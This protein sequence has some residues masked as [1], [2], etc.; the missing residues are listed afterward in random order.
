VDGKVGA[1]VSHTMFLAGDLD[2]DDNCEVGVITT[3]GGKALK[4][5]AAQGLYEITLREEFARMN[6]LTGSLTLT[7]GVQARATDKSISD[8]L[9]GTVVW[10]YNPMECPQTIVRLYKGMMKAYVNQSSSYEGST[11]VVEHQDKDQAAGLEVA[12]LFILCGHHAFR[13][14]IK[15][16]AVFVPK[17]DRMEVAQGRFNGKEGEADLTR[18]ESGMSFM[19][20]RASMS[21]KEKLRQVRR[22]IC[23][24]RRD[25]ARTR[26]EAI[27]GAD[28]PYSLISIFG[29][30]HLAIKAGRAVYVTKCSP[31][32][33]VRRTHTNCTEEIPVVINGTEAFVDPISYVIKS[34]GA[35][36]HCNDV[37]PP[38]YKVGGK[39]YCSYPQLKECHDP[40]ILPVDEVRIDPVEVNNIGLG[41]SI[42]TREQL[43]EFARFQDSQGTRKA[44]LTETAELA[45]RGRTGDGEWGLGLSAA[46]QNFII[47]FVGASF[48]P[49]YSV[50]GPMIFFVSF[51]LLVWGVFRLLVT[52]LIR[53]I[54]IVRCKGCGVWVLTA[55][56]GTL[57]QLAVTPFTWMEEAMEGVGERVGQMMES[58]AC[59]EPEDDGPRRWAISME[60]LRRKYPWWPSSSA[61]RGPS[62][63]IEM[64]PLPEEQEKLAKGVQS[65]KL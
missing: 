55:F 3:T 58:E 25:I 65:T 39:W 35:P 31:V 42:Y 47:D 56:W 15:N 48:F 24:N 12:E 53:A 49:L 33:V 37:A 60:D 30:G 14:H 64:D 40:A 62:T 44:Y 41:K 13:T 34:A 23:E 6:E 16:I 43:D 10:K 20:V 57:F 28:N 11:V 54:I 8:S 29:R 45:Y 22:A 27:A 32:E 5:V 63:L 38:R 7:S 4:G 1:T 61:S 17:D 18:L 26:L 59:R 36:I 50:V 52:V 46:A 9:E 21:M 51:M 19:Q 2:D